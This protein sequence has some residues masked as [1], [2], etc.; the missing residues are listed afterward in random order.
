MRLP[1]VLAGLLAASLL[2]TGCTAEPDSGETNLDHLPA[3]AVNAQD[4][5]A[6]VPGGELRLAVDASGSLNPMSAQ[7]S[8]ELARHQSAFLPSFF[9]YDEHGVPSPNPDF[10]ESATETS[11]S[12]TRVTLTLNPRAVWADGARITA[13]DV[14]ATWTACNGRSAAYRCA[15]DLRFNRIVE[16]TPGASDSEVELVFGGVYPQW[17]GIFDRVSVLRA[18]SVRDPQVFN[19][20]WATLRRE[21]TS[22]PFVVPADDP[23]DSAV[24]AVPNPDW[25]GADQPLLARLTLKQIPTEDQVEA[26]TDAEIDAVALPGSEESF[27]AA[28]N[29]PETSIRRAGADSW[30]QLVFNTEAASPVADVAV[31]QAIATAFDRSGIGTAAYTGVQFTAAPQGNRIFLPQQEGYVDNAAEVGFGR[32]LDRARDLLDDAGWR[33]SDGVRLRDGQPLEV[34]LVRAQGSASAERE[35]RAIADQLAR[36]GIRTVASDAAPASFDDGSVLSGGNFDLIVV[37]GEGGRQPLEGFDMRFGSDGEQNYARLE[38]SEIDAAI[39]RIAAEPDL[40]R[41]AEFANELDILLWE[42]MP[43]TPLYQLPQ[44]VAVGARL[45]NFG[46]PGLASITWENVGFLRG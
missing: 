20:G 45:A 13:A 46:A 33:E 8:P 4:R 19:T 3:S 43:T 24:V 22:G 36:I 44:S 29:F 30:R 18:E 7:A 14:I 16:A 35:T 6:L 31:R 32:D 12:P 34:R 10:L 9:R 25:W 11:T 15:P 1:Q 37:D 39:E 40:T 2:V 38:S 5:T 17:R 23:D 28:R 41:R 21:W 27:T 42:A 26:Y